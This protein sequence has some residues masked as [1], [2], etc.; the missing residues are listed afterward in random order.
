MELPAA[1]YL[2]WLEMY[3]PELSEAERFLYCYAAQKPFVN[4]PHGCLVIW[5][6]YV[7]Q[8]RLR[9]LNLL[10]PDEQW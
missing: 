10:D 4:M 3:L 9:M 6:W 7:G 2:R 1:D 5:D 8:C